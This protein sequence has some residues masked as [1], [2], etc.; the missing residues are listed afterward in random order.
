MLEKYRTADSH[1]FGVA[2]V[3]V[4]ATIVLHGVADVVATGGVWCPGLSNFRD[5]MSF[6]LAS[7]WCK[8]MAIVIMLFIEI[9]VSQHSF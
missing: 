1:A 8:R 3:D 9:R 4:V 7:E 2:D 6:N 5:H